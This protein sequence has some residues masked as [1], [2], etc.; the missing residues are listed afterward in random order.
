MLSEIRTER[1]LLRAWRDGDLEPYAALNADPRVMEHFPSV[2]TREE[3]DAGAER[4]RRQHEERGFTVWAVQ[5]LDS[6]RGPADFVGFTG[7]S[8]P[9]FELPFPHAADPPVEIA[10]RLAA[11]WWGMGIASEAAAASPAYA[12]DAL[13][14]PEV[15][16]WTVPLNRRSRAVMDRIGMSH[17]GEFAHPAAAPDDWWRTHDVYRVARRVES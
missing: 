9:S 5:V 8:V 12:W 2:L 11:D 14:V 3:S 17:A 4:I 7:L 10:W 15:L 13:E 16:A 6:E 1:L